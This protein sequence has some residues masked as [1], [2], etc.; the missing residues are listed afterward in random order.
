MVHLIVICYFIIGFILCFYWWNKYYEPQYYKAK[1]S[2]EGVE[3]GMAIMFIAGL[4]VFW[5]VVL[6]YRLLRY[7]KI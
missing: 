4:L 5:L 1:K 3:E 7:K 6:I 2:D